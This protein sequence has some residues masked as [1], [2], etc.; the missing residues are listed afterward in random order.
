[1][2]VDIA[3][4]VY[5]KPAQTAVT[6]ASLV[7]HSGAHIGRI[8]LQQERQQPYGADISP[9]SKVFPDLDI[10]QFVPEQFLGLDFIDDGKLARDP[11][12]RRSIRYQLAFEEA[13]TRW[14]FVCHNDCLFTGDILGQML[15]AAT[16]GIVGIGDIGQC[17]NCSASYAGLCDGARHEEYRPTYSDVM[18]L[19]EQFPAPRMHPWSIEERAPLPLP[20]CRLNEFAALIDLAAVRDLIMPRGHVMPFGAMTYDTGVTWFRHLRHI[21]LRFK[22]GEWSFHHSPFSITSAGNESLGNRERYREEEMRA[23]DFLRHEFP[24]RHLQFV[25]SYSAT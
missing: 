23:L 12:Y 5:G 19:L 20:E 21:G 16:P 4:C 1:M 3:I 25:E 2:P 15:N 13:R 7:Q 24:S 9:I 6:I 18:A 10:Y 8:W 14:L 17:W 22:H 11:A